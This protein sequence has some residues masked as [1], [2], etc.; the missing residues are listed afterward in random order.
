MIPNPDLDTGNFSFPSL[1]KV[2]S[3]QDLA[4]GII[5]WFIGDYIQKI[6]KNR[7]LDDVKAKDLKRLPNN[8]VKDLGGEEYTQDVKGK[9]GKS[10]ADLYW[11]PK[12][13]DVYSIPKKGGPPTYVDTIP[14]GK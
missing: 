11:N 2:P 14:K 7:D 12:T 4:N 10:K 5:G 13:G 9:S 3:A 6:A 8:K 1:P